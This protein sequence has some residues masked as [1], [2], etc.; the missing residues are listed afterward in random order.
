MGLISHKYRT[1]LIILG[2]IIPVMSHSFSKRR[3]E[4]SHKK[5]MQNS[6]GLLWVV[7]AVAVQGAINMKSRLNLTTHPSI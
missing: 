4:A 1:D 7:P 2:V 6:I 3:Q 5:Q